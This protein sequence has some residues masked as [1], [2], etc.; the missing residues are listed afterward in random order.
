MTLRR[1]VPLVVALLALVALSVT[2]IA[3]KRGDSPRPAGAA[4]RSSDSA[5]A[6]AMKEWTRCVAESRKVKGPDKQKPHEA[7]PD[8]PGGPGHSGEKAEKKAEKKADKAEKR[9]RKARP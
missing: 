9:D 6:E 7:C 1:T 2:A 5:H 3:L 8:K 4:T